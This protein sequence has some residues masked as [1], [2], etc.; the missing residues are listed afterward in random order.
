VGRARSRES[1]SGGSSSTGHSQLHRQ[2]IGWY[3]RL[4]SSFPRSGVDAD[5]VHCRRCH[6]S[7][8]VLVSST[9]FRQPARGRA[10]QTDRSSA[11]HSFLA[12]LQISIV[13]S[14]SV[15][16]LLIV[17]GWI[18]G[19]F[20]SPTTAER[21]A[22]RIGMNGQVWVNFTPS[23]PPLGP[24]PEMTEIQLGEIDHEQTPVA[25]WKVSRPGGRAPPVAA[26]RAHR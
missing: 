6:R 23:G 9:L 5:V 11:S 13:I 8:Y 21:R 22:R 24:P 15:F 17:G 26:G 14:L 10:H 25:E 16:V 2:H 20:E 1:D 12:F 3:V 19:R 4:V 18:H 7:L